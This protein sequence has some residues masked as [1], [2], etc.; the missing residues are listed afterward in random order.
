VFSIGQHEHTK[1]L[2]TNKQTH[3]KQAQ[4]RPGS[5]AGLE[6][7]DGKRPKEDGELREE[8]QSSK[9]ESKFNPSCKI[10]YGMV[11]E[12]TT[13]IGIKSK[14]NEG[15]T[16]STLNITMAVLGVADL[17]RYHLS[18]GV[19]ECVRL[20]KGKLVEP[21][22]ELDNV[23]KFELVIPFGDKARETEGIPD[24][25]HS[26]QG[27]VV[28]E[29]C[30]LRVSTFNVE[31][32]TLLRPGVMVTINNVQLGGV[33]G[34][35]S[36]TFKNCF[37]AD[38][39]KRREESAKWTEMMLQRNLLRIADDYIPGPKEI[40]YVNRV[41]PPSLTGSF[42]LL[43]PHMCTAEEYD[44]LSMDLGENVLICKPDFSYDDKMPAAK[45]TDS[46]AEAKK[47]N[48]MISFKMQLKERSLHNEFEIIDKHI[49]VRI[50]LKDNPVPFTWRESTK[51]FLL[52]K[53]P[54]QI[55]FYAK[56]NHDGSNKART[57]V[58]FSGDFSEK[59]QDTS[60]EPNQE[61]TVMRSFLYYTTG[62]HWDM[63]AY[64]ARE[65]VL[66]KPE[67]VELY[68]DAINPDPDSNTRALVIHPVPETSML[69]VPKE[70][71]DNFLAK[72]ILCI[73]PMLI[74][75]RLFKRAIAQC[76]KPDAEREWEIW[77][78]ASKFDR[79]ALLAIGDDV[80]KLVE[81]YIALRRNPKLKPSR[82]EFYDAKDEN[83][84]FEFFLLKRDPHASPHTGKQDS[85]TPTPDTTSVENNTQQNTSRS[86]DPDN[87]RHTEHVNGED[88][89]SGEE[90]D[91][92]GDEEEDD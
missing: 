20:K 92:D 72:P 77:M 58:D 89:D 60:G 33:G 12:A 73:N 3:M 29:G 49:V 57:S 53:K 13:N 8:A 48:P 61:H 24:D 82:P 81:Q 11:L 23:D 83:C 63:P 69:R 14:R 74:D 64:L 16:F 62:S 86:L 52:E 2:T 34:R 76:K 78:V 6:E 84:Y 70:Q 26:V 45:S 54:P 79:E 44:A 67:V 21:G 55:T 28:S 36:A 75:E 10:L 80:I 40:G 41:Y 5:E 71:Y 31:N 66:V 17:I 19:S 56:Y 85:S 4:K 39:P 42:A 22:K 91:D 30:V 68:M 46:T 15:K 25:D 90:Q 18:K 32:Q 65:G 27:D 50:A 37:V 87:K 51:A 9:Q 35:I 43:C 38:E 47:D 88:K 59:I 1:Q 7:R